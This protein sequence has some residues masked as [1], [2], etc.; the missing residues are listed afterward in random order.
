MNQFNYSAIMAVKNG[1]PYIE[2]AINS[3]LNQTLPAYEIILIDDH[4]DD[5]SIKEVKRLFPSVGI[6][7]SRGIGQA[8]ALNLGLSISSCD[9]VAFLDSDDLWSPSKQAMQIEIL[10]NSKNFEYVSSGVR[11]FRGDL[12]RPTFSQDFM[13]TK[14]L[15][16]CTFRK[17]VFDTFGKF[18]ST[19]HSKVFT[20]EF[21]HR[22]RNLDHFETHTIEL[23]RRIHD[24]NMWIKD[25]DQ[26]IKSLFE[27]LREIK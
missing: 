26:L 22:T 8:D 16:A 20:Y 14:M 11:C 12:F 21:F 13:A 15:G 10:R 2:S 7:H 1:L 18:N 27:L 25:R 3:I 4:S 9:Y 5:N 19:T 24:N 23:N 6:Y 17:S